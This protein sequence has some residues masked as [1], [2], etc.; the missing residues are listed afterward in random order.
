MLNQMRIVAK[1]C[2]PFKKTDLI[3]L[4]QSD[5]SEGETMQAMM[6][7]MELH[8]RQRFPTPMCLFFLIQHFENWLFLE[9]KSWYQMNRS[10]NEASEP[11]VA[12]TAAIS[13]GSR[14]QQLEN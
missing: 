10:E 8:C 3:S 1:L 6:P 13:Q 14:G 2:F 5:D 11:A 12:L 9:L 4:L 7:G